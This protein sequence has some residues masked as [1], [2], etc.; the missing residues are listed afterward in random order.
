MKT[1]NN[2]K[3][4]NTVEKEFAQKMHKA[5]W[6]VHLLADKIH[7]QPLDCIMTNHGVTWFI[8]IKNVK[9]GETFD[10]SRIE[11]NQMNSMIMLWNTGIRTVGFA[12][13]FDDGWYILVLNKINFNEKQINKQVMRKIEDVFTLK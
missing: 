2:K 10:L 9:S 4:G 7:G 8:D 6:W 13:K 1:Y 11:D 3:L 5:G 12:I